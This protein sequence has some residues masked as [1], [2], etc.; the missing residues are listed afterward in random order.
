MGLGLS[1]DPSPPTF[2]LY[3]QNQYDSLSSFTIHGQTYQIITVIG[4]GGEAIVY[5]CTDSYGYQY[6]VKVFDFSHIP[7]S[8][9]VKR[10]E[11]FSKEGRILQLLGM[12]SKYF[13]RVVDYDY[14]PSEKRAYLV[15]E[16]G[17]GSLRQYLQGRPLEEPYRK[18]YWRQI[19][20]IIRTLEEANI[21]HGDIKPENLILVNDT[22]KVTDLGLAF[23]LASTRTS[24]KRPAA[25]GTL[26]YMAPEV[27]TKR[28]GY[29]A[30][31]YSAGCILY[32][33]TYG[34][35]PYSLIFDRFEKIEALRYGF[36]IQYAPIAEPSLI[37]LIQLCLQYD[38][39]LRPNAQQLK[40]HSY[41]RR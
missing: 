14:V 30:D 22:L 2:P 24:V 23:R 37:N 41:T 10:V 12:R 26:D 4:H 39:R 25:R 40:Y 8:G 6:A 36:P 38:S 27:L 17:S 11:K 9:L 7:Y 33:M 29:K 13:I 21:V 32:E 19:V 28:Y 1:S 20:S 18:I 16:L 34:A 31:V 35:P 5:L 3:G 15:M